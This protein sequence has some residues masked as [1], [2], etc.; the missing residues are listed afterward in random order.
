MA[1]LW[2]LQLYLVSMPSE[3]SK[4]SYAYV[5]DNAAADALAA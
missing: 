3:L 5:S 1:F 2:Y 4:S